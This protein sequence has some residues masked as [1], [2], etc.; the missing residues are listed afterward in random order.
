MDSF[1]QRL[2]S[3]Q[4][5]S[6]GLSQYLESLPE[7]AL[8]R[9]S[10]CDLW[11]VGDV[12]G[13]L[14]HGGD[15]YHATV[16][17]GL[18]GENSPPPGRAEAGSESGAS[19]ADRIAQAAIAIRREIGDDGLL[20]AF[21]TSN[22]R[23]YELLAG[24][25]RQ[26]R[27]APCYHGGGLVPAEYFIELRVNELSVHY[28]DIRSRFD[29]GFLPGPEGLEATL[30]MFRRSLAAGAVRWGF[31][32]GPP[33]ETPVRFRFSVEHPAP[34]VT[35]IVVHG[36]RV[37]MAEPGTD[38]PDVAFRCDTPVFVLLMFGRM[39]VEEARNR[40]LLQV[41]GSSELANQLS[42]WFRGI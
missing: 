25:D 15:F 8:D 9:P 20:P 17:R 13:H 32:P 30:Q 6:L 36:D 24:L 37:G 28:W 4:S 35:D 2:G 12:V 7:A 1:Q 34:M 16:S 21:T 39:I 31:W 10:A 41:E 40:A 5:L 23:L 3:L 19:A 11:R 14:I 22:R 29:P 38:P 26:Q 42:E 33:L 18:R 27:G